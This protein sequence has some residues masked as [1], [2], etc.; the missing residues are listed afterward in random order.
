MDVIRVY[1]QLQAWN[2]Q[3]KHVPTLDLV[4]V[5]F[6]ATSTTAMVFTCADVITR[7]ITT[8]QMYTTNYVCSKHR[9]M[10]LFYN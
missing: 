7:C 5:V 9:E 3:A 2:V 6:N 10:L 4:S 8:M 1:V